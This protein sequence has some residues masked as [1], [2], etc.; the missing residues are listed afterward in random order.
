MDGL[1]TSAP[2]RALRAHQSPFHMVLAAIVDLLALTKPEVNVLIVIATFAGFYLGCPSSHAFPAGRLLSALSGT[3]LVASGAGVLNQYLERG[4]DAQMRRTWRRPLAA[5][6]LNPL[7]ALGFGVT[8][9]VSGAAYLLVTVNAVTSMLAVVT[10]T[11]YLFVYTPLKR[12]TP[13]CTLAG[14][15]PGAMPPLIGCAAAS[16]SVVSGKAWILYAVLF[17]WQFPHFMAIAWMY[18]EDYRRAG[19]RILP[20]KSQH[21]FL[22]W[23][24]LCSSFALFTASLISVAT[25]SAGLFQYSATVVPG[26]GLLY[27]ATRLVVKQSR[28][29]ARQLLKATVIYLPAEFLILMLGKG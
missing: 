6:R 1:S 28:T 9:S 22:A 26:A 18:R 21:S 29:A 13:L 4:F 20:V 11:S 10:L 17:L 25:G 24:T 12:K 16:G 14:A 7:T 27:C 23:V 19:Y 2:E 3:L 15:F 8:L 5:R